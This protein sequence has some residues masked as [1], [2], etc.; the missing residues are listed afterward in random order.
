MRVQENLLIWCLLDD[1]R[2]SGSNVDQWTNC[3]PG[4]GGIPQDGGTRGGAFHG[5]IDPC[6]EVRD[7]LRHAVVCPNVTGSA[8]RRKAQSKQYSCWFA[9]HS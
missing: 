7:G 1:L 6:R 8:Q 2:A 5:E 3:S 9:R 4:R